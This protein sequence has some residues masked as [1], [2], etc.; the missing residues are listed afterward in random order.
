MQQIIELFVHVNV[1]NEWNNSVVLFSI[2]FVVWFERIDD[3]YKKSIIKI[4]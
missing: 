3:G 4:K 1:I 2:I